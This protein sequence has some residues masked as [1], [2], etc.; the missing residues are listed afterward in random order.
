MIMNSPEPMNLGSPTQSPGV[1]SNQ[2][3]PQFLLGDMNPAR[4]S[5]YTRGHNQ[6]SG[7]KNWIGSSSPP[8]NSATNFNRQ[9]SGGY[10]LNS[11]YESKLNNSNLIDRS[12][13]PNY[14]SHYGQNLQNNQNYSPYLERS[15]ASTTIMSGNIPQ[16]NE[17]SQSVQLPGAPPVN[18]LV[19]MLN[20]KSTYSTPNIL[21]NS[22]LTPNNMIKQEYLTAYEKNDLPFTPNQNQNHRLSPPSPTQIDPFYTHGESIKM[23]DKL[24]ETW[25]T[26]FGIPQSATSFVLQ[27]FS[28]YG[29]IIRHIPNPQ[30][31]WLHIQY[32]T[33]LQAQKALSKNGKILANSLMVGVMPCIDKRIMSMNSQVQDS[34]FSMPS[35]PGQI[36]PK[37]PTNVN[38]KTSAS[39]KSFPNATK[40]DR[41]QSL[42]TGVRPL[43]P[44]NGTSRIERE[45]YDDS[46]LPKKNGNAISKAMEYMFGW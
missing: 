20:N 25:V 42:R 6:G 11:G 9:S 43:G 15:M 28:V 4:D 7:Y 39:F 23:D 24:D 29:Q 14:H 44:F 30:G 45:S 2:Y 34:Q 16:P 8:R 27:E 37:S 3:M 12:I 17:K 13:D 19:D 38:L 5:Q 18:R 32:Q 10:S 41:T 33:K 26:V 40:L 36:N 1:G 35:T 31:N 46:R 22:N 21:N